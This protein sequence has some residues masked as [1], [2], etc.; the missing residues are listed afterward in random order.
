MS[1]PRSV[2]SRIAATCPGTT[3]V[4]GLSHSGTVRASGSATS[5]AASTP[6]AS[7]VADDGC[8]AL[9]ELREGVADARQRGAARGDD[10]HGPTGEEG[11]DR[12]VQQVR[13]GERL[14]RDAGQ[15]ADLECDLERSA[16]IE[17]AR[18]DHAAVAPGVAI[19]V[20]GGGE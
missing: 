8:S 12:P 6:A 11:G 13:R 4:S 19:E 3:V 15:L 9:A 14:V 17:A 18:D 7:L 5:A 20:G 10:E 16:E 2:A 1:P